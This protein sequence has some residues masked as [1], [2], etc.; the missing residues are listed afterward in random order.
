MT[1]LR[2]LNVPTRLDDAVFRESRLGRALA[3]LLVTTLVV[4]FAALAWKGILPGVLLW[5]SEPV[6][7]LYGLV[8]WGSL[9]RATGESNWVLRVSDRGVYVKF[10]S[11]LHMGLPSNDRTVIFLEPCDLA[12]VTSHHVWLDV[13]DVNALGQESVNHLDFTLAP[14]V[15][16]EPLRQHLSGEHQAVHWAWLTRSAWRY[17][18]VK[19]IGDNVLRIDWR[20]GSYRLKPG[21]RRAEAVIRQRIGLQAQGRSA[22]PA[23]LTPPTDVTTVADLLRPSRR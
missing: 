7:V 22:E 13:P 12:A 20:S 15:R 18:P 21:V 4:A 1:L 17:F 3:A 16:V 23:Q 6:L 11:Y 2:D 9:L 8:L 5:F 10:R 19:L 14:H